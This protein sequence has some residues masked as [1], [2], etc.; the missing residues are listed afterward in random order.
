MFRGKIRMINLDPVIGAEANPCGLA[1]VVNNDP[2]RVD[3]A[4]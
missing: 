1:I 4:L 3:K 2:G